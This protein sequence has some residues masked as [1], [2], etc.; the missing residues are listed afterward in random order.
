M[1]GVAGTVNFDHIEQHYYRSHTMINPT[2]VVPL[3][4]VLDLDAPHGRGRLAA[5]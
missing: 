3:G 2:G 4:P 5:A 1:P